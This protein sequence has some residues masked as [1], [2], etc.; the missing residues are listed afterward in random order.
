MALTGQGV[1]SGHGERKLGFTN[2]DSQ[3]DLLIWLSV[4]TKH[5]EESK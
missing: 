3:K 1:L 2:R 5:G 4:G